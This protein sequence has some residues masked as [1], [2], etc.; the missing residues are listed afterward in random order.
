MTCSLFSWLRPSSYRNIGRR[1]DRRR[2][3]VP[4]LLV[5]E[6]RTLPSTFMVSNL[7]DSGAGS[8]R[9]AVLDANANHDTDQIVFAPSLQGTIALSSGELNVTDNNLTVTGPG[10]GQ[11]A[12]S[13]SHAGRVFDIGGGATVT[14]TGLTITAGVSPTQGGGGIFNETGA[15][16]NLGNVVV[17]DNQ[18]MGDA[19]PAS[20][21]GGGGLW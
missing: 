12:V 19:D 10:A 3:F 7:A 17:R 15:T 14:I 1:A 11:I 8:L 16:L 4:R 2:H 13:G 5:L 18:A 20:A 6:D 21:G 9:Q